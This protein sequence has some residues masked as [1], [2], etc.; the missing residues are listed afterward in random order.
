M[1]G[2][3]KLWS[4]IAGLVAAIDDAAAAFRE[5]AALVRAKT[6]PGQ[7]EGDDAPAAIEQGNNGR[8]IGAK[9]RP[10]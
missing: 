5:M 2:I 10:S 3:T 9:G 7:P 1:F 6:Q 8:R 4:A